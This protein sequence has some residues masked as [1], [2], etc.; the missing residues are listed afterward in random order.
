MRMINIPYVCY[1]TY[2]NVSQ[3]ASHIRLRT[4]YTAEG[5]KAKIY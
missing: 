3:Y 4:L 2:P 1:L 5:L